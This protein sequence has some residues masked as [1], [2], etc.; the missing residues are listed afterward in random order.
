VGR[1]K[2]NQLPFALNRSHRCDTLS[3]DRIVTTICVKSMNKPF[4]LAW[5]HRH[6]PTSRQRI[7]LSCF[8]QSRLLSL[9]SFNLRHYRYRNRSLRECNKNNPANLGSER[10]IWLMELHRKSDQV[11]FAAYGWSSSLTDAEVLECLLALNHE[12]AASQRQS[13]LNFLRVVTQMLSP[14][15]FDELSSRSR[16]SCRIFSYLFS[17]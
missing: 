16:C 1:F 12:R 4:T 9:C 8:I 10:P 7:R 17:R 6:Q 5:H 11:V 15:D 3:T 2:G 13:L 14:Q